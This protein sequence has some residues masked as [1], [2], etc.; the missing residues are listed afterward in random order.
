LRLFL[1]Y[2]KRPLYIKFEKVEW[3]LFFKLLAFYYFISVPLGLIIGLLIKVLKFH[4]T[5]FNY[6]SLRILLAGLILG[7]IIEEVLF[8]FLL[9]PRHKNFVI[10]TC[11]SFCLAMISILKG[12]IIY[13][14]I[15]FTLGVTSCFFCLNFKSLR[16]AQKFLLNHYRLY[17]YLSCILFGFYHI[18]NYIP[19]SY[20][21]FLFMPMIVFPQIVISTFLGYLRMK[22]GILYSI[23][24]HSITNVFPILILIFN[25]GAVK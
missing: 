21:L 1:R 8:R 13:L 11:F 5:E 7:P 14:V 16:K 24:F 10:F 17:F 19:L 9:I 25:A 12:S 3:S 6:S 18:T 4:E 20:K 23:L 2:L 22:F 15:F